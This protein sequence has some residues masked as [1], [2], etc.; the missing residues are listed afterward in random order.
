M[1][2]RKEDVS[3]DDSAPSEP[4]SVSDDASTEAPGNELEPAVALATSTTSTTDEVEFIAELK[5]HDLPD[6]LDIRNI[7]RSCRTSAA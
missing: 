7:G 6:G 4:Q 5:K 3:F 2:H 1:R